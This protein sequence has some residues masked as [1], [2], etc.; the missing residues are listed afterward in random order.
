MSVD[1]KLDGIR[2]QVHRA[3]DEV[4]VFT[5]SLDD[6]TARV[7]EI[8]AVARGLASQEFVL[9]G[10]A[11]VVGP[12]GVPR[13]SR[14]RRRARPRVTPRHDREAALAGALMLRPFFFDVLHAD[15][16]D[17]IDARCATGWPCSTRSQGRSP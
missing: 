6:I 14:R 3:G 2:I 9:D 10:E 4:R 8:V 11:L 17:L 7:P 16:R 5:R 1:T 12:D 13:P 15:G